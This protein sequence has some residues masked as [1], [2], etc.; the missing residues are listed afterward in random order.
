MTHLSP[1]RETI[2][3][4]PAHAL[5]A[6]M[7]WESGTRQQETY[8]SLSALSLPPR[9]E[10][11]GGSWLWIMSLEVKHLGE[12]MRQELGFPD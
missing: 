1:V 11:I 6:R 2:G 8:A 9:R 12:F 4:V 10:S 3:T 5:S 7:M